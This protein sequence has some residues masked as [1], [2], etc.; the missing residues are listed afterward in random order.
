VSAASLVVVVNPAAG[1]GRAVAI[2]EAL[3]RAEP[4]LAAAVLIAPESAA[5]ARDEL[6]Q[7]LAAGAER[8]LALGGDGSFQLAGG[9]V[10]DAGA[11]DRV[12]LGLVAVGTG[13][14]LARSLGLPR[15][16][17]AALARALDGAAR[18]IDALRVTASDGRRRWA[19]NVA[20]A[21]ISAPVD[22]AVRSMRVKGRSAYLRATLAALLRYRE[23]P[24]SVRLDGERWYEGP[25]LILAIAN[26]RSFGNGMLVAPR[27]ELDDGRAD[28]VLIA[29][30]PR[31]RLALE[32]PRIYTGG[33]LTRPHTR[34]GRARTVRV[35]LPGIAP[36]VLDLDG[37]AFPTTLETELTVV[38]RAVRVAV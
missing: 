22:E 5:A 13:S 26:G 33:H 35:A 27:A 37:E 38:P 29:G 2:F 24:C 36:P 17:R 23:V 15:D 16:P 10:L 6:A 34:C 28:A 3:R 25:L 18:T 20:S 4:R 11:G 21:G 14:D 8:V 12:T 30:V 19:F 9:A 31:W 32:L 7:R 1:T